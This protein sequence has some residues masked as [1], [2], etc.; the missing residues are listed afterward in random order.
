MNKIAIIF[1][2][3]SFA[4]S[5]FSENTDQ[6]ISQLETELLPENQ[7]R[8]RFVDYEPLKAICAE[9][10]RQ[11]RENA[12]KIASEIRID[13]EQYISAKQPQYEKVMALLNQL[14][15][16]NPVEKYDKLLSIYIQYEERY[17]RDWFP[18]YIENQGMH[19]FLKGSAAGQESNTG[20]NS[21][22]PY[23]TIYHHIN[24]SRLFDGLLHTLYSQNEYERP[25]DLYAYY[26]TK[27]INYFSKDKL[28]KQNKNN[29]IV[30][31]YFVSNRLRFYF[32]ELN[33][34]PYL[35]I[36]DQIAHQ[37]HDQLI[38]DLLQI[39]WTSAEKLKKSVNERP[40]DEQFVLFNLRKGYYDDIKDKRITA[41]IKSSYEQWVRAGL[42][43]ELANWIID[44]E[45]EALLR[46]FLEKFLDYE[47]FMAMST[48]MGEIE[49]S[50]L[51]LAIYN[52]NETFTRP[53]LKEELFSRVWVD[54]Q[55]GDFYNIDMLSLF[56][57]DEV[58]KRL[59]KLPEQYEMTSKELELRAYTLENILFNFEQDLKSEFSHVDDDYLSKEVYEELKSVV[60]KP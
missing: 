3:I 31:G 27:Y 51:K 47:S 2:I 24:I 43:H 8:V 42:E 36:I 59:I 54:C 55:E 34:E 20:Q 57:S 4:Y 25:E 37:L 9:F 45:D 48:D 11:N 22:N 35:P 23:R 58:V 10:G 6:L 19:S 15:E 26:K 28:K 18:F 50:Y 38:K 49:R 30:R 33:K 52:T 7:E 41:Y 5:G 44:M 14:I 32:N 12:I 17:L 56:P 39:N 46:F 60:N 53:I 1:F 29:E 13:P 21:F 16:E 40:L